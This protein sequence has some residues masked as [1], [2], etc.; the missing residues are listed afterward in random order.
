[1]FQ[2]IVQFAKAVLA[3][4]IIA[5]NTL[6]NFTLMMPFALAKLLLPWEPVRKGSDGALKPIAD[7]GV[8]INS[9]W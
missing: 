7:G 4:T 8:G 2:R 5:V 9:R 3:S 6:V 1:M